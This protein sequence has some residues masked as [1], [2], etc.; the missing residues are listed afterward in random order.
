MY[1]IIDGKAI[2]A[3]VKAE[4]KSDIEKLNLEP[5]LIVILVGDNPASQVYVN[6]KAKACE[7]VGIFSRTIVCSSEIT[8]E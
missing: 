4:V 7:E 5:R 1:K 3:V 8:Q 2:S 6:N